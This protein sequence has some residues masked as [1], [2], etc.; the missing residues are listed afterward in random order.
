MW[1][2]VFNHGI[3]KERIRR[4]EVFV[5]CCTGIAE[6]KGSNPVQASLFSSFLFATAKVACI[7]AMIFL[8]TIRSSVT[9][10]SIVN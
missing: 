3:I 4:Y 7:S 8:Q 1:C 5:E 10:K 9:T 2:K 6:V